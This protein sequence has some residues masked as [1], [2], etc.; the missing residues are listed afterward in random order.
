MDRE[1]F[2]LVVSTPK[3]DLVH[4]AN[5]AGRALG[6]GAGQRATDVMAVHRDLRVVRADPAF[7]ARALT[8]LAAWAR[9]WSPATRTDGCDGIALDVTGC[10]HL[11]GGEAV[12]LED[13]R[14]RLRRLGVTAMVAAAS[15][16][17]AAHAFARHLARV[18]GAVS[19]SPEETWAAL[20]PLP[21][22]SL[23]LDPRSTLVLHR[24]GLK[25]IGQAAAIPRAAL[26]KRF[27]ARRRRDP[28]DD[29]WEDYL[30]RT[31]GASDDVL[32]RLDEALGRATVPFDPAR[33][34]PCPR[35]VEGLVE[36]VAEVEAV[37]AHARTACGRLCA[38]LEERGEGLRAV[39]LEGF[40]TDGG[41]TETVLR[42]SRP[43]RDASHIL[44]LL[45]DRLDDW[46]AEFGFDALAAE[47]L[48]VEAMEPEQ[49]DALERRP[50]SDLHGLIDRLSNRL[51]SDRVL[52]AVSADSHVPERSIVWVP[53]REAPP[54][55]EATVR[56]TAPR[57]DRLFERPEEIGVLYAL[58][59]GPPARFTWRRTTHDVALVAGPERIAPEWWRERSKVRARD[60]YRVETRQGRRFWIYRDGFEGDE[61]GGQPRWFM[62]GLFS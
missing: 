40:R 61:R 30:G 55:R 46:R 25:T 13:M 8:R 47:A 5:G 49:G 44:R 20:A 3:G 1:P 17:A 27:G 29:T 36:P 39:R 50:A 57:P 4:D 53:A 12:M 23:R 58:P 52:R 6:I 42:L 48:A 7:E 43:T 16:H 56:A 21:V 54:K 51:G 26:K 15:C 24:L 2:A 59:E 10:A 45:A 60:Y 32:A 11:F 14:A 18:D 41:R 37:M 33:P 34:E 62:H 19:V 38:L 31:T 28:R 22:A 35:V 9:R